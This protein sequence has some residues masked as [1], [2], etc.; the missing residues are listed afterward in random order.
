MRTWLLTG[1]FIILLSTP[2]FCDTLHSTY[3][4]DLLYL[5][6]PINSMCFYKEPDNN[7]VVNL[8]NGCDTQDIKATSQD[9]D[10]QKNGYIGYEYTQQNDDF[11]SSGFSYYKIIGKY[12][13][14]YT[15]FTIN[16]GGGSGTFTDLLQVKLENEKLQIN[17]LPLG[18][19]RCNGGIVDASQKDSIITANINI[20]TADLLDIT[21]KNPRHLR[22]YDDLDACAACCIGTA[23]YQIDLVNNNKATL[24][25]VQLT[26][27]MDADHGNT[28]K[29]YQ[30][31]FNQLLNKTATNGTL[32]LTPTDLA[33]FMDSFNTYCNN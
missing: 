11:S 24:Q 16:N 31:C 20:T 30:K 4:N 32:T 26:T 14:H 5:G 27:E 13:N 7:F 28:N 25:H 19:D 10:M 1:P 33:K 18:G 2:S 3:P 15:I 22:A 8:A 9:N 23:T 6:K 21:Q 12:A 17:S 29:P